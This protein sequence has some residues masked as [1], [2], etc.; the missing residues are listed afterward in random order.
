MYIANVII[1]SRLAP[2]INFGKWVEHLIPEC[3]ELCELCNAIYVSGVS[4]A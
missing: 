2:M 1:I 3:V 4:K